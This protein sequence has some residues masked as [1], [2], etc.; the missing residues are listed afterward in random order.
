MVPCLTM[1]NIH[2]YVDKIKV[3]LHV[4]LTSSGAP[5]VNPRRM[6]ERVT[7]VCLSVCPSVCPGSSDFISGLYHELSRS[8]SFS[9][10]SLT[11]A[12]VDFDIKASTGRNRRSGGHELLFAG[13]IA[14]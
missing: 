3:I 1:S 14:V 11:M 12:F 9:Y 13:H 4:N 8:V 5:I 2:T 7:V 6:R 10:H